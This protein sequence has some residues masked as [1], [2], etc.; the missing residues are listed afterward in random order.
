M[1]TYVRP[2]PIPG[3]PR[4]RVFSHVVRVPEY[5]HRERS[6]VFTDLGKIVP[7]L[8]PQLSVEQVGRA[9][10]DVDPDSVTRIGE[11]VGA[12][13]P[14]RF[15]RHDY[16]NRLPPEGVSARRPNTGGPMR[17]RPIKKYGPPQGGRRTRRVRSASSSGRHRVPTKRRHPRATIR[18]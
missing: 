15:R 17:D 4:N 14:G 13:D 9:F 1:G 10:H 7:T 5:P 18:R 12:R 2:H 16:A 6:I 11:F 3:D 8:G